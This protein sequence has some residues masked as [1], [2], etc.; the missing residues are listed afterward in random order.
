MFDPSG[1]AN[2]MK[3]KSDLPRMCIRQ[4]TLQLGK[5]A[6]ICSAFTRAAEALLSAWPLVCTR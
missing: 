5:A 4:I 3:P 2:Q 1:I 6:L